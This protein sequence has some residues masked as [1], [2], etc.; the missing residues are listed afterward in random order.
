[1]TY[2][3]RVYTKVLQTLECQLEMHRQG[4]VVTLAMM[5]TGIVMSH[6]TQ[7][8]VISGERCRSFQRGAKWS[9]WAMGS[10]TA[11][12]WWNGCEPRPIDISRCERPPISRCGKGRSGA[13]W[14]PFPSRR[15]AS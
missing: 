5:I 12:R 4:H 2:R 7:L 13:K 14:V 8:A 6:K 3:Y 11:R 9:C 10:M 1:M 15:G